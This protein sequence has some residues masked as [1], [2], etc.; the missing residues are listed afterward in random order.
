GWILDPASGRMCHAELGCG[1]TCDGIAVHAR[2][3]GEHPIVAALGT[4]FLSPGRRERVHAHA[5]Q[6]LRLVPIPRCAAESYPRLVLGRDD[7]ALF[8][9]ILPW[10]HA[11]GVLFLTEAGGHVTHWDGSPYRVGSGRPGVLAA[12]SERLWRAGAEI[13]LGDAAGLIE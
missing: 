10:D 3:T 11:A 4:Q 8:Q 12:S 9:R 2:S 6:S 1:A 13:L 7:L 5:S